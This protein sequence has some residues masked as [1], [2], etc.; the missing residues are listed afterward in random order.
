MDEFLEQFYLGF[1]QLNPYVYR[2]DVARR[3]LYGIDYDPFCE[4]DLVTSMIF[5]KIVLLRRDG[6]VFYDEYSSRYKNEIK[7]RLGETEK[8]GIRLTYVKKFCDV[9]KEK[10]ITLIKEE[11]ED[12][13]DVQMYLYDNREYYISHSKLDLTDAI[14]ILDEEPANIVRDEYFKLLNNADNKQKKK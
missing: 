7:Y 12:F 1:I 5:G 10:P 9:Y 8:H 14:V 6:D 11:T 4:D 3:L 13:Y 2:K